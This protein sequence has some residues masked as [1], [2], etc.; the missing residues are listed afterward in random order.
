MR[1]KLGISICYLSG[2][3][4]LEGFLGWFFFVMEIM[5]KQD[6]PILLFFSGYCGMRIKELESSSRSGEGKQVF[7][8]KNS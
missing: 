5:H 4:E 3:L 8:L 2:N 7:V 6:N 1:M